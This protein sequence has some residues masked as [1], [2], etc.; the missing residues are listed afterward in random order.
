VPPYTLLNTSHPKP[1][2][3]MR[4]PCRDQHQHNVANVTVID[5]AVRWRWRSNMMST[6]IRIDMPRPLE[7]CRSEAGV[8]LA[9]F[10]E[11]AGVGSKAMDRGGVWS[12]GWAAGGRDVGKALVHT[13]ARPGRT[14]RK[15]LLAGA[16]PPCS[17]GGI[18]ARHRDEMKWRRGKP[19][20]CTN[21]CASAPAW[22]LCPCGAR[23]SG[24]CDAAGLGDGLLPTRVASDQQL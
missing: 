21:P 16:A 23:A 4:G 10:P 24:P 22:A 9:N 17:T 1:N 5:L 13:P 19:Q 12:W 11:G 15:S 2:C 8:V 3:H 20:Q 14:S 7:E 18:S 6:M